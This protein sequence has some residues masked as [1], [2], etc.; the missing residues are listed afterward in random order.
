MLALL[1]ACS[2]A[3]VDR[4]P[5]DYALRSEVSC[6][7]SRVAPVADLVVATGLAIGGGVLIYEGQTCGSGGNSDSGGNGSLTFGGC[8]LSG[9][10]TAGG[11]LLMTAAIVPAISAIYGFVTTDACRDA[12]EEMR[13][14]PAQP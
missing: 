8:F 6:T 2:F 5:P 13:P 7:T 14:V 11:V 12:L 4:A 1:P 9:V 10:D 3:F